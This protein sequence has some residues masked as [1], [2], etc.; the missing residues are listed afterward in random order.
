MNKRSFFF[1]LFLQFGCLTVFS[2]ELWSIEKC[3]DYALENNIELALQDIANELND[4]ELKQSK[5]NF[6]PNLNGQ[7]DYSQA[8]GR[9][10][11]PTTNLF[12]N[13]NTLTNRFLFSTNMELFSGLQKWNSL[14]KNKLLEGSGML[15]RQVIEENIQLN[16]LTTYL[17]ILK[18]KEQ[19][20]QARTQ[21]ANTQEQLDRSRSL[22]DAGVLAENELITLEAQ[23]ASDNIQI[24]IYQNQIETGLTDLKI[25]LRLDPSTEIDV[26]IPELPDIGA[27]ERTLEPIQEIYKYAAENRPEVR[28]AELNEIL[29]DYDFKI[30]R[31]A[32]WPSLSMFVSI[33]TNYSDQ[34]QDFTTTLDTTVI[35]VLES[36]PTEAVL[37]FIPTT[38]TSDISYF[39]QLNNNMSYAVGLS[40]NI[41][42]F[43]KGVA[44]MNVERSKILAE[45]SRL[46]TEQT[47]LTLYNTI[48]LAY[49]NAVVAMETYRA[50]QA[51]L[52]A[53]QRLLDSER[54]KLEGGVGT[55][56][57][58]N[59]ASNNWSIASSRLIE[60]KYDY[61]FNV[62]YL[63]FFQGKPIKF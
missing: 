39:R 49:T 48:Q 24:T 12:R 37:G 5:Y 14:K 50:A 3:I 1:L 10:I 62:K 19:L 15:N 63:D 9:S 6:G 36:D 26:E 57:E 7:I 32:Y 56:L 20:D 54:D 55:N 41:P 35:G 34:F 25:L 8:F 51:N 33:S 58:F 38:V 28:S 23:L 53:A 59:V 21:Q 2:Q 17:M 47:K 46:N 29:S 11:D 61:I 16:I 52:D 30:A 42:I 27:V 31:G 40:L 18:S 4:V 60:S 44:R 45:Q 43:N 22:V 13:V